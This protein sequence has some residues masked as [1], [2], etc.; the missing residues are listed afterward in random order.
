[1]STYLFRI[2]ETNKL[3]LNRPHESNRLYYSELNKWNTKNAFRSFSLKY[4]LDGIIRYNVDGERMDVTPGTFLVADKHNEVSAYFESE[5]L[6]RSICIDIRTDIVA[7]AATVMAARDHFDFENYLDHYFRDQV[8]CEKI[9]STNDNPLGQKLFD[10]A[11]Q[12]STGHEPP[13]DDEW[14]LEISELIVLQEKGNWLALNGLRSVKPAT[15]LETLSRL[16]RSKAYMDERYLQNPEMA[17]VAKA[18]NLSEFHFFRSFKQAFGITPYKY[19]LNKRLEH[20]K[21]LL[22]QR[23]T[24][25]EIAATCG[26]S[27]IFSYSKAFKRAFGIS[28][29]QYF[30]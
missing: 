9:Y 19:L 22:A 5:S 13:L 16:K 1:M 6:T 7:E 27:D 23:L 8:L 24:A 3:A 14:F 28:P 30:R 2:N 4:V 11:R 17:E 15:R 20:S 18:G 29:S 26:F 10:L 12:I 25:T 21:T